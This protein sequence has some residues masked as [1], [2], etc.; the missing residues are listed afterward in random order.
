MGK[1]Q[2]THPGGSFA[3]RTSARALS[4]SRFMG[5]RV[6]R[7]TDVLTRCVE[8][9]CSEPSKLRGYREWIDRGAAAIV[10]SES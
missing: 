4:A 10:S 3:N 5:E 6:V 9:S 7:A 8:R 2:T 1:Y